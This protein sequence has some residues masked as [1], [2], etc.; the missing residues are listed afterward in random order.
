MY[1]KDLLCQKLYSVFYISYL[2]K[3]FNNLM[4]H[5][6]HSTHL[7]DKLQEAQKGKAAR[8]TINTV[9]ETSFPLGLLYPKGCGLNPL[10]I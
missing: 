10:S 9:A 8:M 1:I 2:V 6:C 4:M 5:P 7:A 3:S